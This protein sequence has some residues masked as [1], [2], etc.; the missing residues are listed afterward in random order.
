MDRVW[1]VLHAHLRPIFGREDIAEMK[2]VYNF[3]DKAHC[4]VFRCIHLM[5]PVDTPV[6]PVSWALNLR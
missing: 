4:G 5:P 3:A 1:N 6:R 2:A